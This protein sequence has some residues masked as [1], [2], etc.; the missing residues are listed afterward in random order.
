MFHNIVFVSAIHQHESA[1][2]IHMSPSSWNSLPLP[3][4][5][6]PSRLS[7]STVPFLKATLQWIIEDAKCHF[8]Y[9]KNL[10]ISESGNIESLLF[11]QIIWTFKM[12]LP[13]TFLVSKSGMWN[14]GLKFIFYCNAKS[15]QHK[16][17]VQWSTM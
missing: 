5:F 15:C 7:K 13:Y 12:Y 6:H 1:I 2:S 4:P 16:I 8:K 9:E 3:I 10:G 11:L 14:Q 17:S